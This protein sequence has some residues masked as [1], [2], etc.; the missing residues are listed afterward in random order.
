[1]SSTSEIARDLARH[2]KFFSQ[3][4]EEMSDFVRKWMIGI[5]VSWLSFTSF[6]AY[7]HFGG[8]IPNTDKY[9]EQKYTRAIENNQKLEILDQGLEQE[10]KR[11]R[12]W[13]K[14]WETLA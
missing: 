3:D 13:R 12:E 8:Y 6:C 1:L 5:G 14:Q 9:L 7:V 11:R 4:L 2:W 10:L